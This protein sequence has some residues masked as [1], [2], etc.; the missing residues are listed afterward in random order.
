MLTRRNL[1]RAGMCLPLWGPARAGAQG[2]TF[3]DVI[4]LGNSVAGLGLQAGTSQGSFIKETGTPALRP[5]W[6]VLLKDSTACKAYLKTLGDAYTKM[7]A[8]PANNPCSLIYQAW[9]HWYR[10]PAPGDYT[11]TS[12]HHSAGF[13]PWHRAYL[14]YYERLIQ[15]LSCVPD[16]RLAAWDWENLGTVP[17]VYNDASVSP[18]F[19]SGCTPY[20]RA[21]VDLLQNPATLSGWLQQ[22]PVRSTTFMGSD[23][24]PG[25]SGDGPHNT[26]HISLKMLMGELSVAAFDPLFFAHHANI[27]R[28]WDYWYQWYKNY[29]GFF[30]G[31]KYPDSA[32]WTFYDAKTGT[33]VGVNPQDMLT[34][35]NCGYQ[36]SPPTNV[37]L[38]PF[39]TLS[40]LPGPGG[41]VRIA[42]ADIKNFLPVFKRWFREFSLPIT[43]RLEIPEGATSGTY[44]LLLRSR[45]AVSLKLGAF[46]FM[47]GH[48]ATR[49]LPAFGSISAA[50]LM[51][52]LPTIASGFTLQSQP[53]IPGLKVRS[54]DLLYPSTDQ[55]WQIL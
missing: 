12:I 9:L 13:L 47:S 5:L 4:D 51:K 54:L 23:D 6:S 26:V 3:Q 52:F 33:Y 18:Q 2:C 29:P 11:R 30:D 44:E 20:R 45:L 7:R 36:Y 37:P 17:W 25:Y 43:T 21:D 14:Y 39:N 46:S 41:R 1:L 50:N 48:H 24:Q 34:L 16:F 55:G 19:P 8:L 32:P 15:T 22:G 49:T 53:P 38:Y 35:D 31:Q 28:F 42:T 40:G 27:D 10:C